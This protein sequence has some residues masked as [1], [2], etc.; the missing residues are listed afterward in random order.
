MIVP[1]PV[2]VEDPCFHYGTTTSFQMVENP[3]ESSRY[4]FH[5][6]TS[7]PFI[8][9]LSAYKT[10]SAIVRFNSFN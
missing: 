10:Y 7:N 9:W 2:L 3:E 6:E 4:P 5:V 1:D 8:N